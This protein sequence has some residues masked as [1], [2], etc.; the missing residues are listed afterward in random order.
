MKFADLLDEHHVPYE[1]EGKYARP[2]WI[3]FQCPFCLGGSDPNKPYAGYN[4]AY[5]YVNCW[6]CGNHPVGKTVQLLTGLDWREVKS[7]IK[8]I[9]VD[10]KALDLVPKRGK[11][12]LPDGLGPLLPVHRKYLRSRGFDSYELERLW[13]IQGIGLTSHLSWRIFIPID[14]LGQT[15][16]W[17]TRKA[18]DSGSRYISARPDQ[19]VINHKEI[20]YGADYCRHVVIIH[21]GPTDVWRTGPGAVAI[22]GT[23]FKPA[24]IQRL[25]KFL[26]RYVCLDSQPEAQARAKR[27]CDLLCAFPGKTHNVILD[28]DDPGSAKPKEVRQLRRLLDG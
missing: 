15:V 10:Y 17:T 21:E 26:V 13:K 20:L 23:G 2:G 18:G 25:S 22:L 5:N 28:A 16:S 14:H 24:Q 1:T 7:L 19:E 27:L 4:I 8:N 12:V 6:R 9:E 11:L 3:Q